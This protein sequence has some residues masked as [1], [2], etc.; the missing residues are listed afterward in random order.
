MSE[1]KESAS[2]RLEKAKQYFADIPESPASLNFYFVKDG[3]NF[4]LTL[5]DWDEGILMARAARTI[6]T[7][8]KEGYTAKPVGA[9]PQQAAPAPKEDPAAA[10]AK[11]VGNEEA[12]EALQKD[13]A[14][15]PPAP[16]GKEWQALE[17]ARVVVLPQPEER[18]NVE[19]YADGHKYPDVKVVRWKNASVAGLLKHVT[20]HDVSQ[21][22]DFDLPCRVFYTWG[23]E[24]TKPDGTK[25]N[26]KDVGHVRPLGITD[27]GDPF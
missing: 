19:F 6:A 21:P 9:Q 15:L 7:L 23:R 17:I 25:G 11:E 26:Y 27:D 3:W 1:Q 14:E 13:Y 2:E 8:T 16:D 5:R 20:S 10:I 22:G 12:A 18:C 24:Y 4:Q